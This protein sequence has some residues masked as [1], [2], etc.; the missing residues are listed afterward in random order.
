MIRMRSKFLSAITLAL[1]TV[2]N[3]SMP[4]Q[5]DSTAPTIT[6][7]VIAIDGRTITITFSEQMAGFDATFANSFTPIEL[8]SEN[9]MAGYISMIGGSYGSISAGGTTLEMVLGETLS[10]SDRLGLEFYRN[11]MGLEDLAGNDLASFVVLVIDTSGL[12]ALDLTAPTVTSAVL[13]ADGVTLT[14]TFSE[15]MSARATPAGFTVSGRSSTAGNISAG[16]TTLTLTLQEP[17]YQNEIVTLSYFALSN[18]VEDPAGNRLAD[19]SEVSAVTI[20]NNSTQPS[21]LTTA[22]SF[23]S[24]TLGVPSATP[25]T[26]LG[27][28]TTVEYRACSLSFNATTLASSTAIPAACKTLSGASSGPATLPTNLNNAYIDLSGFVSF[29]D[30]YMNGQ[31]IYIVLYETNVTNGVTRY[32]WSNTIVFTPSA[33]PGSSSE[34]EVPPP[35][36]GDGPLVMG[37]TLPHF[38]QGEEGT[39]TLTG[40]RMNKISSATINGVAVTVTADRRSAT[41]SVPATLAAG[42][43][44]I[45]L[46]T[47]NGRLTVIS[48]LTITNR[49]EKESSLN[50]GIETKVNVGSLD[51][52]IAVY[53]KGLK[54]KTLSWKIAGKWR[55]TVIES[56]Y[57][58]FQRRTLD[59]G[60]DVK[61]DLYIDGEKQL[62]TS[63]TTK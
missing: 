26:W 33:T 37:S 61:V 43:Y 30:N 29:A 8:N 49:L 58:V 47:T 39:V 35:V 11:G 3:I 40:K 53:T 38:T 31:Y 57:Q 17:G 10:S 6:S 5:A 13:A 44:D 32:A 20:T 16:G 18:F 28:T 23:N 56:D 1:L 50:L 48:A 51:G 14:V 4:A 63:V 42:T 21:P 25:G 15:G 41:I 34:D 45:V 2:S 60:R 19:F 22:P 54:G 24:I 7:A 62:A 55:K 59:A 27:G 12:P 36:Y 46:Q 9:T 52:R